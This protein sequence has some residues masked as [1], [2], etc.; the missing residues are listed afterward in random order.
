MN[1]DVPELLEEAADYLY[2]NGVRR[3]GRFGF[4][5]GPACALGALQIAVEGRHPNFQ[6]DL[7][8]DA[9]DALSIYIKGTGY[10]PPPNKSIVPLWNDQTTSDDE[11]IDAL[12]L[13]AKNLR[14]EAVIDGD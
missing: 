5:G 1:K 10:R 7:Y 11:V 8:S 6:W 4:G 12:R 9:H 2:V 14:N 3:D 13:T